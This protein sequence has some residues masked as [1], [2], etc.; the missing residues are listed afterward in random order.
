MLTLELNQVLT[1]N[2]GGKTFQL[3][4]FRSKGEKKNHVNSANSLPSGETS[5][6]ESDLEDFIRAQITGVG[7]YPTLSNFGFPL[8]RGTQ[9]ILCHMVGRG[10]GRDTQ[11]L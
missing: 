10:E 5:S 7:R 6:L 1:G 8:G 11:T 4:F 3:F 2:T 9:F